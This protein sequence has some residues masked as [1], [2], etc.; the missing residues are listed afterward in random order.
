MF[1][2]APAPP[3]MALAPL[4]DWLSDGVGAVLK[5][6]WQNGFTS[7]IEI[8]KSRHCPSLHFFFFS[9]PLLSFSPS[10]HFL[11]SFYFFLF[12]SLPYLFTPRG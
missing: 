4:M 3:K 1:G 9:S 6:V 7:S 2:R 10:I 5:N 11:L 12:S 8:V